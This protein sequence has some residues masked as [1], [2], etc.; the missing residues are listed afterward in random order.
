MI[1]RFFLDSR[2]RLISLILANCILVPY[3]F[4]LAADLKEVERKVERKRRELG[5]IVVLKSY[6]QQRN[7][8]PENEEKRRGKKL[9]LENIERL[10]LKNIKSGKLTNLK[11]VVFKQAKNVEVEG[12]EI[13]L[14]GVPLSDILNF[15]EDS[16]KLGLSARNTRISLA[17]SSSLLDAYIIFTER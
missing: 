14:E 16:E 17:Q 15:L 13:R 10:Y 5:R 4:Y 11:P 12:L 3:L 6:Y 9:S 7:A 2:V 1:K 8:K